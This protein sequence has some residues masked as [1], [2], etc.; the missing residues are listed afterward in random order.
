M[1]VKNPYFD[2]FALER[3]KFK[4]SEKI[5]FIIS[6]RPDC[7]KL[8][9]I[10]NQSGYGSI[11]DTTIYR[12][13]FSSKKHSPF[14]HTMDIL[15]MF[16]GFINSIELLENINSSRN[17]LDYN[18]INTIQDTSNNLMFYCIENGTYK[19]LQDYFY[20][21]E[22][23]PVY[24]KENVGLS[25]HDNLIKSTKQ[26]PVFKEFAN[27]KFV[28]EYLLEKAHDPKFRI[29]NYEFAYLNY[30]EGLDKNKSI[31]Q[32]QEYIFGNSVLFRH[33]YLNNQCTNAELVG[34]RIYS[35]I[36]SLEPFE[37]DIYIFPFIRFVAYKL[38]YLK[39]KCATQNEQMEYA[40][41]L[42]ELCKKRKMHVDFYEKKILFHTVAE[43]F[44]QSELSE[45]FHWDLKEIFSKE[46]ETF[47]DN[48]YSKHLKYCLHYFEPNGLIHHR[49]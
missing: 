37:K 22:N 3:L 21:L 25:L 41:Y 17:S 6:N 43:A 29:K 34:D 11:S 26:I 24:V 48:L 2:D 47:P 49:P 36:V 35:N 13:F 38:W 4:F 28:R 42:L 7:Y 20:S 44:L 23:A 30:L 31:Q 32:L 1:P 27:H 16:L 39:M 19:P 33:Y 12:L 15:A 10:I 9:E 46:F 40:Y 8:S 14:K 45:K 18:G 5:G